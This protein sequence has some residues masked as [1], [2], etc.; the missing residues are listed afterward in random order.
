MNVQ[1]QIQ[2]VDRQKDISDAYFLMLGGLSADKKLELA[3]RLIESVRNPRVKASMP[4]AD[5]EFIPELSA[6]EL[7]ADLRNSRHFSRGLE[8]F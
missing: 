7:I 4:P 8:E 6:E 1:G 2:K 3:Q 5:E